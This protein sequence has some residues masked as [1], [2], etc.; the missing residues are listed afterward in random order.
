MRRESHV[1]IC[2]GAGGQF[3]RATRPVHPRSSVRHERRFNS[4]EVRIEQT[5]R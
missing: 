5:E 4:Q 1:R 3:P 2:E